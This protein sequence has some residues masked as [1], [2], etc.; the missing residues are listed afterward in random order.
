MIQAMIHRAEEFCV[1][2]PK[3]R[4][5]SPEFFLPDSDPLTLNTQH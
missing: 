1:A 5:P 4:E 2:T 3:L